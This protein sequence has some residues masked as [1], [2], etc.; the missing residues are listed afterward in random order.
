V[1]AHAAHQKN[2]NI[3]VNYHSDDHCLLSKW[4]HATCAQT[5]SMQHANAVLKKGLPP[6]AQRCQH[7]Q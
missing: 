6:N 1:I 3:V 5:T 2:L 4:K 7:P